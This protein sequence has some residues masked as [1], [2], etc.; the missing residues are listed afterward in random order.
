MPQPYF[1]V[2]LNLPHAGTIARRILEALDRSTPKEPDEDQFELLLA[3][4]GRVAQQ[5]EPYRREGENPPDGEAQRVATEVARM[6][7][8]MVTYIER[9]DIG[10]DRLGQH[11]R[12]LFECLELGQEG[13]E[14]SLRAGEDPRSPQ[15]PS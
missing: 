1:H 12:N 15:R 6:A 14:I 10:N 11:I 7:R 4:A 13:A 3:V 2:P 8:G 9:L 5:L